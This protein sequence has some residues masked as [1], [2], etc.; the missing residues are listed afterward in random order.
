MPKADPL[1]HSL[2]LGAV[3]CGSGA[4]QRGRRAPAGGETVGGATMLSRTVR[5]GKTE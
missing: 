2:A 5:C 3:A 4:R 1:Q